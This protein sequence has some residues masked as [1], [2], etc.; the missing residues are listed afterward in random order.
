MLSFG[1]RAVFMRLDR[2]SSGP[3]S[4][5]AKPLISRALRGF[6][7]QSSGVWTPTHELPLEYHYECAWD[8][9]PQTWGPDS[10]REQT[11]GDGTVPPSPNH[12]DSKHLAPALGEYSPELWLG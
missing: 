3:V 7:S 6:L 12:K 2:A 4:N 10:Q 11:P 9:R 8:S 5:Q 1:H